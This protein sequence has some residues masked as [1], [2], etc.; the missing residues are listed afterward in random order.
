MLD[1]PP[2]WAHPRPVNVSDAIEVS[3]NYF[4][5]DVGRR[6]GIEKLDEYAAKFGLGQKTGVELSEAAG[7]V[8]S[9]EFTESLGGTWYEGNVLSVAIGQESTQVTPIQLANYISTLANGGNRYA[10]H[11]L[12][13]VKSR[14]FSSGLLCGGAGGGG[15][16]VE[17]EPENLAAVTRGMHNMTTGDGSLAHVFQN[18]PVAGGGQDGSAQVNGQS[19]S[20]AVFVCYAPYDDPQIA[21]S[22]A[23]EKGG[24]G[25]SLASIAAEILQY[26]FTAQDG[27]GSAPGGEHPGP[28]MRFL[29][30][31]A[32]S[33]VL[34]KNFDAL[35]FC[36]WAERRQVNV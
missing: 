15:S 10:T 35:L 29:L 7:V 9:P 5:Y 32:A 25:S 2:V 24:S 22:I 34:K 36:V 28:L 12:K 13:T 6:V 4:F 19:N 1:L 18:V 23:V 3:C 30:L 33:A 8:A 26:Y 21:I 17:M 31:S 14:D 20:N 11:L 27:Q 16:T